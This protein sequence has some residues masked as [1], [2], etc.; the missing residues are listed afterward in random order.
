MT[1]VKLFAIA[2]NTQKLDGG[3]MYG[4]DHWKPDRYGPQIAR[5]QARRYLAPLA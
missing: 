4:K 2:G 3:A 1:C 5:E